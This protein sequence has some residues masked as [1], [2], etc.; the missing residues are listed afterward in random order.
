[1]KQ[2]KWMTG[3]AKTFAATL[4]YSVVHSL[5]ASRS[6]KRTAA[7]VF[8]ARYRNSFYRAFYLVQSAATLVLLIRYIQRQPTRR[9]FALQ[10]PAAALLR[11][12]QASGFGWALVAAFEV[13]YLEILGLRPLFQLLSGVEEIAPEPEAQ[14]PVLHSPSMRVEGPFQFSRHPLNVAPVIVL[15]CNPRMTTNLLAYNVCSTV[16]LVIGSML[17]ERRLAEAY[18]EA[19]RKYQAGGVSFY[20]PGPSRQRQQH[21]SYAEP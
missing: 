15:W 12:L 20:L 3:F 10:G 6:A 1:M 7:R 14:G 21:R 18:G 19:Y 5:F 2:Q 4:L 13:G 9:L 11:L 17:E 8:G 16:Y